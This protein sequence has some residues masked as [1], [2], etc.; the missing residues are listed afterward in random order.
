MRPVLRCI[1]WVAALAVVLAP[2]AGG[3]TAVAESAFGRRITFDD[4]LTARRQTHFL[5]LLKLNWRF[6]ML[7]RGQDAQLQR[8]TP[9]DVIDWL[10]LSLEAERARIDVDEEVI[11]ALLQGRK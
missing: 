5:S 10:L 8:L 7:I 3:R 1:S 4:H 11:N 2:P 9:L 6:P